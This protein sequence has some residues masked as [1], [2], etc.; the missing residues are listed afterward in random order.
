MKY[1]IVAYWCMFDG[2]R[3]EMFAYYNKIIGLDIKYAVE[4][5]IQELG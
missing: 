1:L 4:K 2:V 3:F 5:V